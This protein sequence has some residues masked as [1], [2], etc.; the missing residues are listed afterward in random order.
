MDLL[1]RVADIE[2]C[3]V[4]YAMSRYGAGRQTQSL[5]VEGCGEGQGAWRDEEVDVGDAGD[6]VG[7]WRGVDGR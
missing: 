4:V 1:A 2:P 6:H 7:G 3:Q 5:A